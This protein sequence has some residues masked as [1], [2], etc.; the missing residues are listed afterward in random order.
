MAANIGVNYRLVELGFITNS[1]DMKAIRN[2]MEAITKGFAEAITGNKVK[3]K[4]QKA[5]KPAPK[6]DTSPNTKKKAPAKWRTNKHGTQYLK[7]KGIWINGSEPVMSRFGSPMR[8]APQGG[9][10]PAGWKCSYDEIVRQD[11]HI[12]LGYT[13][14]GRRKYIP[15]KTWNRKTGAVGKDWGSFE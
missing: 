12:W 9:F 11:G 6:K 14:N 10:A 5:V 8:N 2:N 15:V 1:A 4:P 3:N 13:V 7:A